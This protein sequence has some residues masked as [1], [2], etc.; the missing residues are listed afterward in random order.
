MKY[1]YVCNNLD[2]VN[3]GV[4][5]VVEKPMSE[6]SREELCKKCNYVLTRKFDASGIKT[7]DGFK[8]GR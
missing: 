8:S 2:C 5:S 1:R 7:G 3:L 4:S 6:S